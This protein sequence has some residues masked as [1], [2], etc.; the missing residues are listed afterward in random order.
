MAPRIQ[1]TKG[2]LP[3]DH[4][5]FLAISALSNVGLS[6]NLV[7]LSPAGPFILSAAMLAGRMTPLLI[8]WWMADTTP[9]ADVAVG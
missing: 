7:Q 1:T 5:L 3:A 4:V 2:D 6:H 9:E 8:L